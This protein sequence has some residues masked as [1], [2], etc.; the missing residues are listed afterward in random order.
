[1]KVKDLRLQLSDNQNSSGSQ[2]NLAITNQTTHTTKTYPQKIC[3]NILVHYQEKSQ[4]IPENT[5][6]DAQLPN[7]NDDDLDKEISIDEIRNAVFKYLGVNLYKNGS[8]YRTQKSI[9]EHA[10]KSMHRLFSIFNN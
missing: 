4:K 10:S 6:D 7:N 5:E 1:M 3:M 9:A 2:L 8:W